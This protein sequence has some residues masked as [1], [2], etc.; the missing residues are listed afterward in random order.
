MQTTEVKKQMTTYIGTKVVYA[1]PMKKSDYNSYRGW[2]TPSNENS[3]EEGYLVEY[4][5]TPGVQSNP[6]HPNH[7]N[8]IS[9][10]PKDVFEASYEEY[11]ESDGSMCFAEA[12]A[13]VQEGAKIS[14][15]GWNGKG[16]YIYYVPANS[17]PAQTEV[18]KSEF[19]DVVPYGA[20]L[21]LKS[22]QNV[23]E[24]GWRPTSLD[25]FSNDWYIVE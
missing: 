9:W 21:A 19:G 7:E 6:N 22:A 11:V 16:M 8:Y 18:A 17:Y 4:A 10:S 14:R 12:L 23:V 5:P 25:M 13:F 15:K 24:A 1:Q 3:E 20:Y 2:E